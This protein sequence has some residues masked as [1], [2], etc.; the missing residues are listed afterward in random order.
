MSEIFTA[1]QKIW[2]CSP[3]VARR[4]IST[5]C[6]HFFPKPA[7]D[8]LPKSSGHS[9]IGPIRIPRVGR[10]ERA[11]KTRKPQIEPEGTE[12]GERRRRRRTLRQMPRPVALLLEPFRLAVHIRRQQPRRRKSLYGRLT[13]HLYDGKP[14][15][16]APCSDETRCPRNHHRHFFTV[17]ALPTRSKSPHN[18]ARQSRH[19]FRSNSQTPGHSLDNRIRLS[20]PGEHGIGDG[21]ENVLERR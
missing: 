19:P 6:G 3:C 17:N 8:R 20:R 11:G 16:A 21:V 12:V 5:R 13:Q 9:R 1:L 18:D 15:I 4:R 7:G 2:V 10:S 14:H